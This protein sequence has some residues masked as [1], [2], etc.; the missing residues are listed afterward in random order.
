MFTTLTA[1]T[2]T[3]LHAFW[4][5]PLSNWAPRPVKIDGVRYANGEARIMMAK[6]EL[7]G[8]AATLATMRKTE[9]PKR[10][11]ALGRDVAGFRQAIWDAMR[12]VISRDLL[13]RKLAQHTDI[14]EAVLAAPPGRFVEASPYDG[15]WGV[16]L[17]AEDPRLLDP[18]QWQG[19]NY[20]GEDY[21]AV[22]AMLR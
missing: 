5:G 20:L 1:V 17:G 3:P 11:K 4:K 8:D 13:M 16:K 12:P 7:F 18:T 19:L 21:D 22:I 15:L 9:D 10:L 2:G 6:A 14:R